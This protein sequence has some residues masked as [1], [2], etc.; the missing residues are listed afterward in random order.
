MRTVLAVAAAALSALGIYKLSRRTNPTYPTPS[1]GVSG[2][3]RALS[4]LS[5]LVD[6]LWSLLDALMMLRA[7]PTRLSSSG[8]L[9]APAFG[10]KLA[11]DVPF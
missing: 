2:I 7:R 11:A 1:D 9:Q 8:P 6:G 4:V 3:R 5:A 10:S